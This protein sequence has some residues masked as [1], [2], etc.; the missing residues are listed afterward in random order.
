MQQDAYLRQI[1]ASSWHVVVIGAGP[2][3]CVAAAILAG[4]GRRVLLVEKSR[5]PRDKVCGGCINH[6]AIKTLREAGLGQAIAGGKRLNRVEWRVGRKSLSVPT[7]SGV[8]MLR[9][10]FDAALAVAAEKCGSTFLP[11]VSASLLP[12]DDSPH[13]SIVLRQGESSAT[14]TAEIVLAC[15]GIGGTSVDSEPWSQWSVARRGWIG[16]AATIDAKGAMP[17]A[18]LGAI[19]MHVGVGGYVGCVRLADGSVH[20][21]AALDPVRCRRAGGPAHLVEQ[22][23]ASTG[24]PV[25]E[26]L[27]EVRFRGT[28]VM[29]RRRRRLG[30]HRVIAV[31]DAGGYV[32]PF[33]GEGMAWAVQSAATAA[34]MLPEPGESWAADLPRD[35]ES[36]HAARIGRRQRLCRSARPIVHHPLVAGAVIGLS[37]LLPSISRG[38]AS[39]VCGAGEVEELLA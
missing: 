29:T 31:G 21:A 32:E 19:C 26:A 11:G 33:T 17:T 20:L 7:P 38:V 5:W 12:D 4:Q 9:S 27:K 37:S 23:L 15:D 1:A 39:H 24:A 36:V 6:S 18:R 2:A 30:G 16:V 10:E 35:W 14:I 13:R 22:I 28:G 34:Q 3:G 8:A 25:G